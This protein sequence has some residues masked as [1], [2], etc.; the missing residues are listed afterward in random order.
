MNTAS[1]TLESHILEFLNYLSFEKGYSTNTIQAYRSD[2]NKLLRFCQMS[3]V[4]TL[5]NLEGEFF[6]GFIRELF[7]EGLAHS[8]R[9][10]AYEVVKSFFKYLKRES[11][12]HVNKSSLYTIQSEPNKIPEILSQ[13][14]AIALVESPLTHEY[15]RSD[16]FR[17]RN[18]AIFE[19]LYGSG[20]RISEALNLKTGDLR[21]DF[22]CVLGKGSK[23]RLVP[24]SRCFLESLETYWRHSQGRPYLKKDEFLFTTHSGNPV[25]RSSFFYLQETRFKNRVKKRHFT[26]YIQ[27]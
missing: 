9:R 1:F 6:F 5:D 15:F 11:I 16:P 8:S 14:E 25:N 26:T 4:L 23:E 10:R 3:E 27:T 18:C 7:H 12:I 22:A 19:L 21:S 2:L 13:D 17:Y 20:L 24:L